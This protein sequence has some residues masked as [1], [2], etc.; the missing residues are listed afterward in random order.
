[1][2][3]KKKKEETKPKPLDLKLT[4]ENFGP[5][6]KAEIDLK[7]MTVFIGPNNS[8]KSYVAMMFYSLF[9]SYWHVDPGPPIWPPQ[10]PPAGTSKAL[11]E[12]AFLQEPF[13]YDALA[14]LVR[15]NPDFRLGKPI[16]I[17]PEVMREIG[18]SIFSKV[19]LGPLAEEVSRIYGAALEELRRSGKRHFQLTVRASEWWIALRY[20]RGGLGITGM[21]TGFKGSE[22]KKYNATYSKLTNGKPD[23]ESRER[24]H[25]AALGHMLATE[26]IMPLWHRLERGCHYLPGERAGL[27]LLATP[28]IGAYL[29][30]KAT[31]QG[32]HRS[33]RLPRGLLSDFIK[34]IG[35]LAGLA[36]GPFA[37]IADEMQGE[38]IAGAIVVRTK[39]KNIPPA[40]LYRVAD[41]EYGLHRCSSCISELAPVALW[42]KYLAYPGSVLIID[43][44]EAHLHPENQKILAKYLVRLVRAGVNLIITTHSEYL[45]SRL[46]NFV[47]LGGIEEAKRKELGERF[48]FGEGDYLAE[49]EIGV[50]RFK[51]DK[52]SKAYV[53]KLEE[54]TKEGIYQGEFGQVDEEL[55]EEGLRIENEMDR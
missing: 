4:L 11:D 19:S 36:P 51:Y 42:I 31:L 9:R 29:H 23:A 7:P 12:R 2:S 47:M 25:V 49:D 15:D 39:H 43:E 10:S 26:S 55:Y 27:T 16:G 21:D 34:N 24:A 28:F 30:E 53:T 44:P 41:R 20:H 5:L 6:R 33:A 32:W 46:S 35:E 13:C 18:P 48:D 40:F 52:R 37:D 50:Y 38:I 8:G 17:S 45:L 22:N 3:P 14:T 54:A 1:M